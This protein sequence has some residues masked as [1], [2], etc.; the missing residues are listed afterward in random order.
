[1]KHKLKKDRE[2]KTNK[3]TYLLLNSTRG[4]TINKSGVT[5]VN[6]TKSLPVW[7]SQPSGESQS[8]Y[9]KSTDAYY[10]RRGKVLWR[11]RK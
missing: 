9:N 4:D 8:I 11:K 2:T 1:M 6:K 10:A 7:I 3:S 5:A